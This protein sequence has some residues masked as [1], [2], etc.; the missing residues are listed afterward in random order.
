MSLRNNFVFTLMFM[1]AP[2]SFSHESKSVTQMECTGGYVFKTTY[3]YSKYVTTSTTVQVLR[4]GSMGPQPLECK[5][6]KGEIV[7]TDNKS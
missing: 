6:F 2:L 7:H 5:D 1:F 4:K 3:S